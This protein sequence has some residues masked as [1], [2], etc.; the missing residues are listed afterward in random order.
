MFRSSSESKP[1]IPWWC[2][3]AYARLCGACESSWWGNPT[4]FPLKYQTNHP[5][6]PSG[7]CPWEILSAESVCWLNSWP[8]CKVFTRPGF[9]LTAGSSQPIAETC[10]LAA[11]WQALET[12]AAYK[13]NWKL[14]RN[15]AIYLC[16]CCIFTMIF[17]KSV[18]A[19][20]PLHIWKW[21]GPP[22]VPINSP[23]FLTS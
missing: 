3:N 11:A 23:F 19:Q 2:G 15:K 12:R 13:Y 1:S 4:C 21:P 16:I 10:Y 20:Y 17:C 22:W 5:V 9:N 8:K 7:H 18:A 6:M 14:C